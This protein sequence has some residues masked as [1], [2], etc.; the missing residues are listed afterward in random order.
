MAARGLEGLLK[1]SMGTI[2]SGLPHRVEAHGVVQQLHAE[3]KDK[4]QKEVGS[5]ASGRSPP[6]SRKGDEFEKGSAV[7][8]PT[9]APPRSRRS[10]SHMTLSSSPARM[11][12]TRCTWT[13]PIT[14]ARGPTADDATRVREGMQ[15]RTAS[16]SRHTRPRSTWSKSAAQAGMVVHAHHAAEI[17][18]SQIDECA[19]SGA[20]APSREKRARRIERSREP[21]PGRLHRRVPA[22]PARN[23]RREG[24]RARVQAPGTA[25][26]RWSTRRSS[27]RP[28]AGSRGKKKAAKFAD[29]RR[30]A[31][32]RKSQ[33]P[34]PRSA[35]QGLWE[36]RLR[37]S[38]K[39]SEK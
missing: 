6:P 20:R 39:R 30:G 26:R 33:D 12:S 36:G 22:G 17:R 11:R 37:G 5:R 19:R 21:R 32:K 8:S 10:T 23:L 28:R 9:R 38:E 14:R 27:A 2:R 35:P 31:R 1:V 18:P 13:R 16:E 29:G 7:V 24:R 4:R 34:A 15:G 25:R 3:C